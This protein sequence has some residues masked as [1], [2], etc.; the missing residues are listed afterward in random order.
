M[1]AHTT[2]HSQDKAHLADMR[3]QVQRLIADAIE[4]GMKV[5]DMAAKNGHAHGF[6]RIPW[7]LDRRTEDWHW[8]TLHGLVD[9]AGGRAGIIV[10]GLDLLDTPMWAMS[11]HNPAFLGVGVLDSLRATRQMMGVG[12][13]EMGRRLHTAQ[14][15]I[16]KLEGADDPRLS[17][18]MRYARGLGGR[19]TFTVKENRIHADA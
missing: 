14:S 11:Q 6:M 10:R 18:I 9:G 3:F 15:N 1:K 5:G 17:S 4:A 7:D 12:V 8:T 13:R 2:F 16:R 19:V